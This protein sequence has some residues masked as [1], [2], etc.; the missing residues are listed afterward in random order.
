[1]LVLARRVGQS[2]Q[3]DGIGTVTCLSVSGNLIR[4]GF[5]FDPSIQLRRSEVDPPPQK[6][7]APD[8]KAA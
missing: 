2:V 7:A 8:R 6:P 4:L 3:V 1:M 5:D